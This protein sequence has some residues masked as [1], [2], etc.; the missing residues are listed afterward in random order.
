MTPLCQQIAITPLPWKRNALQASY[1]FRGVIGGAITKK[2][3]VLQRLTDDCYE[4]PRK[5]ALGAG[6]FELSPLRKLCYHRARP[7]ENWR[8]L[9]APPPQKQ[10]YQ[11]V[12]NLA[13]TGEKWRK[14]RHQHLHRPL[15]CAKGGYSVPHPRQVIQFLLDVDVPLRDYL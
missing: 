3:H 10:W 8:K 1:R 12:D 13:K 9:A 6:F 2:L 4:N 5:L 7:R 14:T 11:R 15:L